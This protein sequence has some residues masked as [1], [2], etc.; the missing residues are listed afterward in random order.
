MSALADPAMKG[1]Y[2]H[3]LFQKSGNVAA[4]CLLA[5][6]DHRPEMKEV[7]A[8]LATIESETAKREEAFR[9]NGSGGE[10]GERKEDRR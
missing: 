7:A 2:P 3:D 4:L 8:M 10:E 1:E 9:E 6:G 5:S